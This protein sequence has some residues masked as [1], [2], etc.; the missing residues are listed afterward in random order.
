MTIESSIPDTR[1][2]V[3]NA[4]RPLTSRYMDMTSVFVSYRREDSRHQAGRLYDR[5]VAHFG[6]EQVFKDVDSIPLGWDFREILTER[7]AGCDV[8]LAVIGDEWL[9]I[10]G[11]RGT[12]RLDDPGDFVR[13]EIEAALSRKIPVIP[14][15]V[16]N[17]SVPPAEELPESLRG[18][19]FRNGLPVRPDPDFHKDMDRLIRGIMGTVSAP[20]DD[21]A[22]VAR[23]RPRTRKPLM[24][25]AAVF[26]FFLFGVIIYVATDNG[27]I[28]MVVNDPK[29]VVKIDG[30]EVRIEALGAPI[31]L[32]AGEHALEVKWGDGEFKTRK[33][34]VRRGENE[35]LRVE[36][37][38][39]GRPWWFAHQGGR[40]GK[41][42]DGQATKR[43]PAGTTPAVK[44]A[45]VMPDVLP[46]PQPKAP[47]EPPKLITN[48]IGMKLVLIPA[49]E[50]L[51][52]SPDSDKDAK[53]NEKPQHR[54]RIT[55][56][57]YLGA[58]EVTQGQYQAVT[59]KNP[60]FT[61]K[62]SGRFA[63]R[64]QSPGWMPWSSATP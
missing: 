46:K 57:F 9:S 27:R 64:V 2:P 11:K 21:P 42:T 52:G 54:V 19:S 37:E 51:M 25:A 4:E 60:S 56:P 12:R 17:S 41:A 23:D 58:T 29:A 13:I 63:G 49:G 16:G 15:L 62:G 50:F 8:F 31:T 44:V 14:V 3:E 6:S 5:L 28:T 47:E 53:D 55:R 22:A 45:E 32:R 39:A 35:D 26:G 34:V 48:K 1:R 7:V 36:Y 61:S 30:A 40:G 33:F 18:L 10:S 20:R 24:V 38:P 59:G 43:Q